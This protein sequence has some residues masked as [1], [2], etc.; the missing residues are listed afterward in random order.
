MKH[1]HHGLLLDFHDG[2]IGHCGR[3]TKAKRLPR[4]AAFSE[5][6]A[7]VQ[8][9]DGGFL[10]DLRY[11]SEPYLSFLYVENSI[12]RTALSKDRLLFGK[13]FDLSS[14]VEWSRGMSWYRI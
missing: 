14:A 2:A 7:L 1:F 11:D 10:A 3:G 8:I 4:K 6:I 13:G 9:A 12:R 5:E